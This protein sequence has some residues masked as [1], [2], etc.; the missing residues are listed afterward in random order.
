MAVRA[1]SCPQQGS[2]TN[3][4]GSQ[5]FLVDEKVMG[6]QLDDSDLVLEV[7]GRQ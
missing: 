5:P 6:M 1:A 4:F 2:N 3:D 7:L